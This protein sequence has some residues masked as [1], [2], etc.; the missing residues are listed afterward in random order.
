MISAFT[1][2]VP[3]KIKAKKGVKIYEAIDFTSK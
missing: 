1:H 2:L 3:L